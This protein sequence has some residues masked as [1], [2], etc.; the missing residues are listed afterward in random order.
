MA[1]R[2]NTPQSGKSN[3]LMPFTIISSGVGVKQNYSE[4]F[5]ITD[6][7][8]F[9]LITTMVSNYPNWKIHGSAD[10]AMATKT[11]IASGTFGTYGTQNVVSNPNKYP[12]LQIEVGPGSSSYM[13]SVKFLLATG[14]YQR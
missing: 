5:S 10:P 13:S 11:E 12:Y 1:I 7:S 14:K 8:E 9:T 3:I 2:F 4:I 6:L